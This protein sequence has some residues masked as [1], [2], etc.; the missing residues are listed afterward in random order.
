LSGA[1]ERLLRSFEDAQLVRLRFRRKPREAGGIGIPEEDG[2]NLGFAR[3]LQRL[4][5][6]IDEAMPP[7]AILYLEGAT[8]AHDVRRLLAERAIEARVQPR[9]GI[10][11]PQSSRFH[12][13]LESGNL[14]DLRRL[15]DRHAEPEVCDH[16]V[17]Y[18]DGTVPR[19]V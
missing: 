1:A 14:S 7:G 19:R 4:L 16:L 10:I 17:V 3:D 9:R 18:A 2:V 12:L 11:L 6:A 5:L 8:I 15:A 13:P